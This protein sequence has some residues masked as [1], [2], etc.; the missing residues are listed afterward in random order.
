MDSM[1]LNSGGEIISSQVETVINSNFSVQKVVLGHSHSQSWMCGLGCFQDIVADLSRRDSLNGPA[2]PKLFI[3]WPFVEK[4]GQSV[5]QK[6]E[7]GQ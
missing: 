4:A 5:T 3:V 6:M 2:K 1:F 7:A